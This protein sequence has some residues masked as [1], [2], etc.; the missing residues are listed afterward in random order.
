MVAIFEYIDRYFFCLFLLLIGEMHRVHNL[1]YP[2]TQQNDLV[3]NLDLYTRL[4]YPTRN[5]STNILYQA[6]YEHYH[7]RAR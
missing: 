5:P 4:A 3:S 7:T 2:R 1:F 6:P